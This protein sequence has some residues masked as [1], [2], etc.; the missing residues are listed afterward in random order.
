MRL[1]S[2]AVVYLEMVLG[3]NAVLAV[4]WDGQPM[5]ER[6]DPL[7]QANAFWIDRYPRIPQIRTPLPY[8][9]LHICHASWDAG[10]TVRTDLGH[11]DYQD[12]QYI[13]LLHSMKKSYQ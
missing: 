5:T 6:D 3:R 1:L 2:R 10:D 8:S 7:F 11:N 13:L 12:R 4:R 9:T